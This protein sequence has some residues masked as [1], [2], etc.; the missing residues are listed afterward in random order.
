MAIIKEREGERSDGKRRKSEET[1]KPFFSF[2]SNSHH[3]CTLRSFPSTILDKI[4][5]NST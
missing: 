4:K 2:S 5:W 3:A 1:G